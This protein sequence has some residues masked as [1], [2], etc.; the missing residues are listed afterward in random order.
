MGLFI[1]SW[2]PDFDANT[3]VVSRMPVWVQQHNL[4]LHFWDQ[5]VLAG[6]G[7][8]IGRYIKMDTQRLDERV[9]TFA[10]I[11]VKV[12]L[13]KGLSDHKLLKHSA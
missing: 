8:S 4:P 10:R 11:C 3:M 6:I 9:Y 1:T 7:N 2:F 13:S 12:D 5:Q